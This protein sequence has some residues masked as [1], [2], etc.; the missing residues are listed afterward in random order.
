MNAPTNLRTAMPQVTAW[1]DK[2]RE[3]FGAECINAV[4][5]AGMQGLP[6]FHAKENGIEVGTPLTP[7]RNLVAPAWR[8]EDCTQANPKDIKT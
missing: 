4:I 8:R 6:V 1:I 5:K 7:T 2:L 3:A